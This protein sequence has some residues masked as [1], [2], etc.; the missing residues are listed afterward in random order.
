MNCE[1]NPNASPFEKIASGSKTFELS[2]FDANR[3]RID[4]GDR[5][6]FTNLDNPIVRTFRLETVDNK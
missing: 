6:V 1:M 2:L 5:I 4:I 3:R